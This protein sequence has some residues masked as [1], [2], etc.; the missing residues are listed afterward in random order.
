MKRLLGVALVSTICMGVVASASAQQ[1]LYVSTTGRDS[2][3]GT[4]SAPF[5]TI[6]KASK[7]ALSGA[8]VHVAPGTYPG[9]F[10]T[11]ANGTALARIHYLSDTKWGAKL[12]PPANS[13]SEMAWYNSGNYVDIDGF[14]VDGSNTQSGAPWSGGLYT[15]GSYDVIENSHVHN[16]AKS[17]PCS[18]H[19]ASAI[20]TDHYNYGVEDD[21]IGNVVHN[22]GP[23]G[24][25]FDQGIYL[26]TSGKAM[27]NLVY[28]I[29]W[30][31]I[32]LWHDATNLTIVNNTVMN[33]MVGID[34]G[35]GDY[36]HSSAP[37]DYTTVANNIVYGNTY[38]IHEEGNTGVHNVYTNNLVYL[39]ANYDYSLQNGLT[40]TNSV[41]AD[42]LFVK[43][44][45]DYHLT[46]SSP[47]IGAGTLVYAPATDLDGVAR[48][49]EDD[50]GAYQY[51]GDLPK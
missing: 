10:Q 25:N 15:D 17:V 40:P 1:Q 21:V 30:I 27:N 42:P 6:L 51:A 36:Y 31:G 39:N 9:G 4:A 8:T 12:V 14:E 32:A 3:P 33:N 49:G 16:I 50:I 19:G 45:S 48:T 23:P 2:N 29:A 47:A 41:N 11:T 13:N 26:S 18:G 5:L 28:N 38:G 44:G 43:N 35:A 22:I 46:A 24:C 34:I 7:V 37:N 20:G